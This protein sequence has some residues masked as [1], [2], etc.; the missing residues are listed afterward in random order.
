MYFG[1]SSDA[2]AL[3]AGSTVYALSSAAGYFNL[4]TSPISRFFRQN[5]IAGV[6]SVMGLA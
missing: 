1:I 3:T 6:L 5:V 4:G 2:P